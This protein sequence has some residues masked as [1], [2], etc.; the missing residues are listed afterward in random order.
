MATASGESGFNVDVIIPPNDVTI[1]I[2]LLP[3][4]PPTMDL[5]VAAQES[6]NML[7]GGDGPI[8]PPGPTGPVGATGEGINV[9][10]STTAPSAPGVGDLWVVPGPP[11]V[12]RTWDGATWQNMVTGATGPTGHLGPTGAQG[13]TGPSGVLGA[14]GP[15]GPTGATGPVGTGAIGPTGATGPAGNAGLTGPLL[16]PVRAATVNWNTITLSGLQL[17]DNVL[18]VEGDRVLVRQQSSDNDNGIYIASAN[19]WVRAPDADAT[20][21]VDRGTQVYVRE[22]DN[23][24]GQMHVQ[25]AKPPVGAAVGTWPQNWFSRAVAAVGGAFHYP[26]SPSAGE[27]F[28]NQN[29][30]LIH[31]WDGANWLPGA[32]FFPCTSTTRPGFASEGCTIY[33]TDTGRYYVMIGS[34]WTMVGNSG[35]NDITWQTPTFQNGWVDY[36]S[37][38]AACAYMRRNSIIY[39]KGLAKNGTMGTAMFTLPQGYRPGEWNIYSSVNAAPPTS[40]ASAGTAHTHTVPN[41]G[42]RIDIAQDGLVKVSNGT[43][44]FASISGISF[45]AEA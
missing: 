25:H 26:V 28:A 23:Y 24:R 11:R 27:M 41:G 22:G 45:V 12:I 15:M 3:M 19:A 31:F 33:E 38:Y 13:P 9:T 44:G 1:G 42:A 40:G 36:G 35:F 16:A 39:L 20:A 17:V 34:T 10:E 21:K 37:G 14:T 7:L 5:S 6:L 4:E 32:G 2:D 30:K 29:S 43:N 18:T 8:G